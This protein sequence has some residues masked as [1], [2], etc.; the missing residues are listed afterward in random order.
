[1]R[2]AHCFWIM[3][4]QAFGRIRGS[5]CEP[6]RLVVA[7]QSLQSKDGSWKLEDSFSLCDEKALAKYESRFDK[8]VL[9]HDFDEYSLDPKQCSKT[10]TT[11]TKKECYEPLCLL[12]I[13]QWQ[14][15]DFLA[16]IVASH[17][18]GSGR[19]DSKFRGGIFVFE[20][21]RRTRYEYEGDAWPSFVITQAKISS[22]SRINQS[23]GSNG[24]Q[25][26]A[27]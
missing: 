4:S 19:V 18:I 23:I 27:R 7:R 16:N 9:L 25:R 10:S 3:W 15:L 21:L 1:M 2:G 26:R 5:I 24:E 12:A 11:Y 14:M 6:W 17:S 8:T 20:V 22:T 13:I